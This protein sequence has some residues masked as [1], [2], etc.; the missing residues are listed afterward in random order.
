MSSV[1]TIGLP[2]PIHISVYCTFTVQVQNFLVLLY[3]VTGLVSVSV[4]YSF[5][6][7]KKRHTMTSARA[8]QC[9][10]TVYVYCG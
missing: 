9:E 4:V 3:T 6:M 1:A 10:T 7:H 2:F 8:E 5:S